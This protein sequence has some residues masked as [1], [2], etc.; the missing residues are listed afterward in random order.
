MRAPEHPSELLH[1]IPDL[2]KE[3][4]LEEGNSASIRIGNRVWITPDHVN[5]TQFSKK[6][7]PN[8][9]ELYLDQTTLPE[10]SPQFANVHL[11][12]YKERKDF[13]AII[14]TTQENIL[15]CSMAGETVLP[16]LDDMA[17]IV[18]PSAKVVLFG[19]TEEAL[20]KIVKGIKR[21]NAVMIKDQGAVCGHRT[22]D[23]LHAVCHVFEKA[24]KS[25]IEARIL[26]GGKPVPW[27]EAEA[28]RFVYQRKYS[29]QADKN[30]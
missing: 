5:F 11:T 16:Y 23:D 28:I 3:G 14:H 9:V 30:R 2:Q 1:L 19:E 17:Q 18:G 4:I 6:K 26:G 10:N 12:L 27:L 7:N 8:W 29:K 13:N 25:F 24:C 20:K 22:L 15:T 21:R